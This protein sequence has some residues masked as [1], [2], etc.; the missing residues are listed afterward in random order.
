MKK[1][2]SIMMVLAMLLAM[3]T[4]VFAAEEPDTSDSTTIVINPPVGNTANRTYVAYRLLNLSVSH[5]DPG[6]DYKCPYETE[7]KPHVDECYNYNYTIPEG[8][9]FLEILQEE[10]WY[11]TDDS[12]WTALKITRPDQAN[13]TVV[14]ILTYLS[15]L[16]GDQGSNYSTL[17]KTADR[18]YR[19]IQD[20]DNPEAFAD[21]KIEMS[22]G[23]NL[24]IQKGYWMIVETTSGLTDNAKTVVLLTTNAMDEITV[25]PKV[26]LPVVEKKVKDTDDS[27]NA[28]M[29]D[30]QWQDAA[31]HDI[32]D[33]IPFKLT[34]TLPSN[35]DSFESY[36]LVFH[37][38][39]ER[40]LKLIEGSIKVYVYTNKVVADADSN[41]DNSISNGTPVYPSA[42]GN[43]AIF[44]LNIAPTHA[45][46]NACSFEFTIEDAKK[47]PNLVGGYA[48]G[49]NAI[50]ITYEAQLT[51][52]AVLGNDGNANSVYLEYYNDPYD[53]NTTGKTETD[54][55]KV[56]TYGLTI[57]KVDN[58][59]HPLKGAG[60]KLYKF[61]AKEENPEYVLVGEE[62]MLDENGENMTQFVWKGLDDGD[63][64]LVESTVPKGYNAMEDITFTI[65]ATHTIVSATTPTLSA[66]NCVVMGD[67]N[68]EG[69]IVKKIVNHTGTV[70]PETGAEGTFFLLAGGTLLVIVAAVF[71]ITRKKMSIYED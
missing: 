28:T 12:F 52:D 21:Y 51:E 13:I 34:A 63:Y 54:T 23:N 44:D 26:D 46:G 20:A 17:R 8:S 25:T 66:V 4:A 56:F 60:F 18:I 15:G 67:A 1:F 47:I 37:D 10:V 41:M 48:V 38:T 58:H 7:G 36:K 68:D 30:H 65:Q 31:D 40:G 43:D 6:H 3:S 35:M 53:S 42:S 61:S 11:H 50:V 39:M 2:L 62:L 22:T 64:K 19:S 59:D 69:M 27:D 14:Q 5:K 16:I 71:M 57:N 49:G 70:L 24:N 33:A 45:E 55:V 9:P 29:T 32:G